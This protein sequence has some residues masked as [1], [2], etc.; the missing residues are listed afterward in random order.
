MVV[1]EKNPAS[2]Q[3]SEHEMVEL[4][5]LLPGWQ[6]DAL[7]RVAA[8]AQLTIGQLLRRLVNHSIA[9]HNAQQQAEPLF[10]DQH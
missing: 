7:E 5:L 6:V 10:P 9:R 3:L 2:L 8:D 4:P 1:D